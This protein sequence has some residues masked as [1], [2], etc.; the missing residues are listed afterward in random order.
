MCVVAA[1]LGVPYHCAV[2]EET[3]C[4]LLNWCQEQ[5][6]RLWTCSLAS[7]RAV[8]ALT[9]VQV[10]NKTRFPLHNLGQSYITLCCTVEIPFLINV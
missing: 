3:S 7:V 1:Y 9:S 10:V 6:S 2:C 8:R 5:C 4:I